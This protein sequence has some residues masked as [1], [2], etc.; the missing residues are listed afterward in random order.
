MFGDDGTRLTYHE[1]SRRGCGFG[2]IDP[3]PY[4]FLQFPNQFCRI[5]VNYSSN[6][7]FTKITIQVLLTCS[8][9]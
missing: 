4:Q 5:R 3:A 9:A 7:S 8:S 6:H 1:L 2:C